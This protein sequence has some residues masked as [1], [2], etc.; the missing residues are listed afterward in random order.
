MSHT[1]FMGIRLIGDMGLHSDQ[2]QRSR[3]YI[4]R[5][6]DAISRHGLVVTGKCFK[7]YGHGAFSLNIMLKES[8]VCIHTWPEKGYYSLDMHVCNF[9]KNNE[10]AARNIFRE[11]TR[12]LPTKTA[13]SV[14]KEVRE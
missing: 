7:N 8:H 12:I 11:I 6:C 5:I 9:S 14:I 3:I 2:L 10:E 4:P 13:D 1:T